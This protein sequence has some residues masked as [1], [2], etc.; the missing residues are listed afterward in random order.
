MAPPK[1]PSEFLDYLVSYPSENDPAAQD[2]IYL[3][4]LLE[5]S[6]KLGTSVSSLREQLEVAKTLG[7]VEVRPRTGIRRLKFSFFPAVKVSLAY[8]M[9]IDLSYFYF[10]ADLRNSLEAVYWERAVKRLTGDDQNYLSRLVQSAWVKLRGE[11]I[12]IPHVEHRQ[13]HLGIYSRL[14]NPFVQGLLEAY[15]DAYEAIGYNLYSDYNYLERVWKYHQAMVDSIVAGE[16]EEGY[17][18][19]I[20]HKDLLYQRMTA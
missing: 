7:M 18:A 14:E 6:H 20:E 16:F 12:Q 2:E 5:L 13:L 9:N 11:P 4:S 1:Q 3:P 19:L 8:S 10:Y 17:K 15:W